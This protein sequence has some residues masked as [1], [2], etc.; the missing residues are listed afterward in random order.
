MKLPWWRMQTTEVCKDFTTRRLFHS[1]TR[2]LIV[3]LYTTVL[4]QPVR[5]ACAGG[6]RYGVVLALGPVRTYL[7]T[8]PAPLPPGDLL[9]DKSGKPASGNKAQIQ[10]WIRPGGDIRSVAWW[11]AYRL[12][13]YQGVWAPPFGRQSQSRCSKGLVQM[14]TRVNCNSIG[15]LASLWSFL[16]LLQF[17]WS[18]VRGQARLHGLLPLK[19]S[20]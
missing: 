8:V 2:M 9:G 14:S 3:Y 16:C 6:L 1:E 4:G 10:G 12:P 17:H 18:P 19:T 11:D 15:H 7:E 5:V 20:L 13:G